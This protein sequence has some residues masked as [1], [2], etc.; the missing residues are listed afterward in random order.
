MGVEGCLRQRQ[1]HKTPA[2]HSCGGAEHSIFRTTH[3]QTHTHT[4]S[5]RKLLI[6]EP[7]AMASSDTLNLPPT[8]PLC[9][10][11]VC[12][13]PSFSRCPPAPTRSCENK[14]SY[15]N[16]TLLNLPYL[17]SPFAFTSPHMVK[18]TSCGTHCTCDDSR[19]SSAK[20]LLSLASAA[21][22]LE[23]VR[24]GCVGCTVPR[25]YAA[26]PRPVQ[27]QVRTTQG[28]NMCV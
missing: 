12:P 21:N 16:L 13:H 23:G 8:L 4:H 9:Y 1:L 27:K 11:A 15:S 2:G 22:R 24:G 10:P 28:G 18:H 17:A 7:L 20:A 26:T 25:R 3:M 5:G 14:T 6:H 19:A